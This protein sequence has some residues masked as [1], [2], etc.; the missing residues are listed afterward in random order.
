MQE[1]ISRFLT[2]A[3]KILSIVPE[4]TMQMPRLSSSLHFRL[5]GTH[6]STTSFACIFA[7]CVQQP[8]SIDLGSSDERINSAPSG[9][10][11][12]ILC[13]AFGIN[14]FTAVL[15]RARA[16]RARAGYQAAT[17]VVCTGAP[18]PGALIAHDCAS[19]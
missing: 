17:A 9:T 6:A 16:R 2:N 10:Q 19:W 4:C 8:R 18:D 3:L 13:S 14:V 15:W 12:V 11:Q 1:L 7:Q 5:T